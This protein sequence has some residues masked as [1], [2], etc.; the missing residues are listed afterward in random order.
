[1]EKIKYAEIVT[2]EIHSRTIKGQ[3][4]WKDDQRSVSARPS[5]TIQFSI[6]YADDGPDAATWE[7][8]LITHPVGTAFTMIGNPA[9]PKAR[10]C[11]IIATGEMLDE[12]NETFRHVLLDP[13]RAAFETAMKLLRES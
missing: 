8:V 1:L 10:L 6:Y 4:E 12:I 5:P 9:S 7:H 13:R 2:Q 11:E 3:L